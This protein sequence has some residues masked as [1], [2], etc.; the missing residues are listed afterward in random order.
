MLKKKQRW[1][2]GRDILTGFL[3]S[4]AIIGLLLLGFYFIFPWQQAGIHQQRRTQPKCSCSRAVGKMARP[5]LPVVTIKPHMILKN[6]VADLASLCSPVWM[7]MES[8]TYVFFC[9]FSIFLLCV[10]WSW[11]SVLDL[12]YLF[13]LLFSEVEKVEGFKPGTL[14][15]YLEPRHVYREM[16]SCTSYLY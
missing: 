2:R 10:W 4:A 13:M 5:L 6:S 16:E 7:K 9:H 14:S 15:I 8:F 11:A 12:L 1:W 3:S